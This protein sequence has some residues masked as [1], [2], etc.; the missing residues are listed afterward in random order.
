[1][2]E[3]LST[4]GIQQ[5]SD[6]MILTVSSNQAQPANHT[7]IV[8]CPLTNKKMNLNAK[9]NLCESITQTTKSSATL[10]A[11]LTLKENNSSGFWNKQASEMSKKLWLPTEIGSADLDLNSLNGSSQNAMLNSW[12]SMIV[13]SPQT[14]L[15]QTSYQS[16]LY[17]PVGSRI[18]YTKTH[19]GR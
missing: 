19:Q 10:E 7:A 4:L 18:K 3:K 16:S 1:M 17:F 8:E 6:C 12:F 15:V 14:E 9:K 5:V 13:S 11:E 2:M